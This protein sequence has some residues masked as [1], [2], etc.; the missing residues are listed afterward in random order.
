MPSLVNITPCNQEEADTWIF[1]H[2]KNAVCEGNRTVIIRATDTDV[3]IIAISVLSNLTALGLEKM[4]LAY[5]HGKHFRYITV[6]DIV[7]FIDKHKAKRLPFFHAFTGCNVV[8]AF[9]GKAKKSAWQTC[10][11]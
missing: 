8:S 6:H 11:P 3:L 4:W 7:N 2:A 1:L 5:E 9:H 10:L